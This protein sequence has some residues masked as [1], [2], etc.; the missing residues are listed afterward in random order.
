MTGVLEWKVHG[1]FRKD[2]LRTRG[3]GIALPVNEQLE[4]L[5]LCLG[6]G[7]ELRES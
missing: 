5:E 7:K 3:G 1:L 4:C 2:R 6:M